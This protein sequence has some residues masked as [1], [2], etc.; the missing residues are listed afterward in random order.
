[1]DTNA[2]FANNN[3]SLTVTDE[4][5]EFVQLNTVSEFLISNNEKEG[6]IDASIQAEN[7]QSY[8]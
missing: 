4:H 6:C 5:L 2:F 7:I 3:I 1:M 8:L